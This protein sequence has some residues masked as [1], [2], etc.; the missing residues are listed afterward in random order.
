MNARLTSVPILCVLFIV[1]WSSGFVGAKFGLGH[2]GTF[3]LLFWR[4]LLVVVVLGVL[5]TIAGRWQR[6]P[7]RELVRHASVG[8]LAH[9]AWLAA[10]LGAIDLGLSAGLAAFITALQPIVTGAFSARMT[11]EPVTVREWVGLGLGLLAVAIVI[12]DGVSLGGSAIAHILPVLA[13]VSITAASLIDRGAT[14]SNENSTPLLLVTFCHSVAAFLVLTPFAISLEGLEA[15][16]NRD[17][18]FSVVWLAL[19][20]SLA[21]Y[22]LMF[23]L[24]RRLSAPCVASLTYLS[25]PVTMMMAWMLFGERLTSADA[26]GLGIAAVSV[27]LTLTSHPSRDWRETQV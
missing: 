6:I 10:V 14:V 27:G 20:V 7:L 18:I 16:W 24:L 12:G 8:V 22:G 1:L 19:V 26:I 5:V 9:A 23:V 25:P 15:E 4:Y 3:T 11:G 21:A 2:S 13:V 17:L